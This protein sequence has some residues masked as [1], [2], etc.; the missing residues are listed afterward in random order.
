MIR[1]AVVGASGYSGAELVS[2]LAGHPEARIASIHADQAAGSRWGRLYPARR[3][4]YDGVLE[5]FDPDA[6]AGLDAV[7]LALPSGASAAAAARLVGRVGSVLDLSGD[8]RLTDAVAYRRW[9]GH[10]HPAPHLLG[11]A[12]YGL[13]EL[14]GD[15]L[16][17]APLVACAGCYATV[18]QLAAAPL[19]ARGLA[20]GPV[21]V[22]ATSGTSGAGRK[23]DTAL[24]HAEVHGDLRPYRVGRHQH[25]PEIEAGLAR[26]AGRPVGVTFVPNLA[27]IERG[28]VAS[29]ML[30]SAPGADTERALDTLERAYARAPFVRVLDE[31]H[32][33]SA[34]G[35]A[36]TPYCDLTALVDPGTGD[37]VVL[38][39][40]DNLMK[41]AASQAVQAMNAVFGFDG[42]AGL[43]DRAVGETAPCIHPFA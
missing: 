19:L 27:P 33:P 23:A 35:V 16:R 26:A 5:P 40:I 21:R 31:G 3:H 29:V 18:V 20:R 10:D 39:A 30:E 36:G 11:R 42:T 4:R 15:S 37:V 6:L 32:L 24:S 34:R 8:L 9:Y 38:G 13:P 7:F 1:C 28:I 41:G 22:V 2:L 25:V 17:D 43:V 12:V 14:A